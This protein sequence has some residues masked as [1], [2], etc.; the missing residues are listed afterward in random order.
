VPHV[1]AE[2]ETEPA[3]ARREELGEGLEAPLDA[4]E[5]GEVHAF[6]PREQLAEVLVVVGPARRDAE[7]AV[8][9]GDGRDAV[10][11]GRVAQ[12]VPGDLRVIVRVRIDDARRDHEPVGVDGAL[13]PL[14]VVAADAHHPTVGDGDVR[15]PARHAGAVD[16]KTAVDEEVVHHP[17]LRVAG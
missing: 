6:H 16:H 14:A 9:G 11:S 10:E 17:P 12:P 5:G 15:E 2:V 1:H 7:A 8:P 3:G 13:G 4:V